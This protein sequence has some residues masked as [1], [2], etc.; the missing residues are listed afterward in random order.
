VAGDFKASGMTVS[1]GELRSKMDELASIA[2]EQI[3]AG[4]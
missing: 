3:R 2:R 4:E 1:E